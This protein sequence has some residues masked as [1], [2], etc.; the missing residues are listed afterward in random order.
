MLS[1]ATFVWPLK[2]YLCPVSLE[3]KLPI[4]KPKNFK[5]FSVSV[6][7]SKNLVAEL[8]VVFVVCSGCNEHGTCNFTH[9]RAI[10]ETDENYR[11]ATCVCE[12]Y[13]DGELI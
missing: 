5:F 13:W 9:I 2:G 10:S 11:F 6:V 7:D 1:A 4:V 8:N 3:R 12:P